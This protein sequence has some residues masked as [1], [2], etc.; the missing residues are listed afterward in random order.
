MPKKKKAN[1]DER[2]IFYF[3]GDVNK[4]IKA[5]GIIFYKNN[6][7]LM[8]HC[9]DKIE[10]F[11]GKSDID[12]KNIYDTV[13]RE[14]EEE[15]NKIFTVED[16]KNRIEGKTYI[17]I[18]WSKYALFFVELMKDYDPKIFGKQEEH[19]GHNRNIIW[20]KIDD[21]FKREKNFRLNCKA[22]N[23]KMKE[24]IKTSKFSSDC[25][26]SEEKIQFKYFDYKP[27][28]ETNTGLFISD[29]YKY[30]P[31]D[32][33]KHIWRKKYDLCIKWEKNLMCVKYKTSSRIWFPKEKYMSDKVKILTENRGTI[34]EKYVNEK[35]RIISLPFYKFWNY[36]HILSKIDKL[37]WDN[38]TKICE[39]IDGYLL[40]LFYYD[41]QD[42]WYLSTSS[43]VDCSNILWKNKISDFCIINKNKHILNRNM[44][45]IFEECVISTLGEIKT[46]QFMKFKDLNKNYTYIF[47][48]VHPNLRIVVPYKNPMVYHIG[49][50]DMTTLKEI[51]VDINIPKPKKYY[52]S[53]FPTLQSIID[54]TNKMHWEN[55][56]GYII[57]DRNYHRIKIKSP[58]YDNEHR[59]LEI[60]KDNKKSYMVKYFLFV[61]SNNEIKKCLEY[62]PEF[63]NVFKKIDKNMKKFYKEII[64]VDKKMIPFYTSKREFHT[65]LHKIKSS[66]ECKKIITDSYYNNYEL[67]WDKF[68]EVIKNLKVLSPNCLAH[69]FTL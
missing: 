55:G 39:K 6:K 33:A 12:D 59:L 44:Y 56:E 34:Y 51:E 38:E 52:L 66:V 54:D 62:H 40:K 27:V 45:D 35:Y 61:W 69:F 58:S 13:S 28:N 11:G 20:V 31:Y 47:E 68:I 21:F 3:N 46:K 1:P 29:E 41:K 64:T 15:S 7:L 42:K 30:V 60:N 53:M 50:R 23:D 65:N 2:P 25:V 67:T 22:V 48:I 32:V 17:Y 24:L 63:K 36:N 9:K 16:I 4:E 18:P 5:G 10:D 49:T 26:S 8:I 19:D 57:C 14:V 37:I 43:D